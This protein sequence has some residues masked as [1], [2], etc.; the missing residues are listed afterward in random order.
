MVATVGEE[1]AGIRGGDGRKGG[2]RGGDEAGE[3]AR[4]RAAHV[5]LSLAKA[6]SIGLKSGE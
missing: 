1:A 6:S 3:G 5:C 2:S 4:R